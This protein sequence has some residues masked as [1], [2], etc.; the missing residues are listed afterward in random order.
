LW[1]E[2]RPGNGTLTIHGSIPAGAPPAVIGVSAGNPTLWFARVV[3][4]RLLAAGIDVTGPPVDG[5]D[6]PVKPDRSDAVLLHA[7]RSPPLSQIAA[8]I[9]E[10]SVNLYAEAVL[11]LATGPDGPRTTAAGLDAVR[12]RLDAW[13]IPR[14]GIQIVDG[15]G[16]SRRN[17][18]AP[19]TLLAVL[20]R[21]HDPAGSSPWMNALAVAGREGTLQHRMKGTAA[22][23]NALAKSGAMSNIR[24]M[25][26]YVTSA[27]GEPLAFAIMANNFEGPAADVNATI[28]RIV[29]RLATFTRDGQASPSRETIAARAAASSGSGSASSPPP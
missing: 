1:P 8:P 27:D 26:G 15:S 12:S 18:V 9:L 10:D 29:A 11:R 24:T 22:E 2:Y 28:D 6:L 5:D 25:A 7:H 16:L 4:N 19:E 23:G 17:V 3:R 21:L 14:D 20:R 13:G